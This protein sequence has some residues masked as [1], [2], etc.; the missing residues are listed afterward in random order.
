MSCKAFMFPHIFYSYIFPAVAGIKVASTNA[1]VVDAPV[2][3]ASSIT[4]GSSY[5]GILA[6]WLNAFG[7]FVPPTFRI[8]NSEGLTY[9]NSNLSMMPSMIAALFSK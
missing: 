6:V 3:S 8:K 9:T 2:S 1:K 5:F 4:A 7:V